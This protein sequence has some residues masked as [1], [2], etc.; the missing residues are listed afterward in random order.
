M[1]NESFPSIVVRQW[2]PEWE[3]VRFDT[4]QYQTRPLEH[5]LLFSMPASTLRKLSNTYRRDATSGAGRTIDTGIQ[6][7]HDQSRSDEISQFVRDGY[8]LSSMSDGKRRA[9]GDDTRKPGWLPTAIVVNILNPTSPVADRV[10]APQDALKVTS[11]SEW[12][13][14]STVSIGLPESWTSADWSPSA[15]FP[16]EVID[17]QHRLWSF[18]GSDDDADYDLPVV[19]FFGLD[20]SWQAYLFWTI[21][22]KP[23]KINASLA[24]DLYPLLRDQEWLI[25]GEGLDVYREARAQ[26]LTESLWIHPTSAWRD[27]INMLGDP[28]LR[29]THPV[30]QAAFVRSLSESLVRQW[31]GRGTQVGGL[32]GGSRSGHGLSWSR[33]QQAAFL[34]YAWNSLR[35]SVASSAAPW[36]RTIRQEIRPADQDNHDLDPAFASP[37]SLLAT[38]QGIRAFHQVL[39]DIFYVSASNLDLNSW[40]KSAES[41]DVSEGSVDIELS[42]ISQQPWVSAIVELCEALS[43]FDWRTSRATSLTPEELRAKQALRGSGGYKLLRD[44]LL[45]HLV[46]VTGSSQISSYAHEI[47]SIRS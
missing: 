17:G 45:G 41:E 5:F 29:S 19:A 9:A 14:G 27:R 6:R 44:D 13:R 38:D 34:I 21:N 31:Q 30:T 26:E 46:K 40:S 20:V 2:M 23:K 32:F 43:G 4:S 47:H 25:A 11:P 1:P 33:G 18:D 24:Y 7:R 16:V 36:A 22:I 15:A 10:V 8:P 3:G 37:Y 42:S 35:D 39:N 12:V 28:G